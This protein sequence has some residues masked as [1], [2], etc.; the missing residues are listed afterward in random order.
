MIT[1]TN[2]S[3][4]SCVVTKITEQFSPWVQNVHLAENNSL[5]LFLI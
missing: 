2:F 5:R 4:L 3:L 1:M